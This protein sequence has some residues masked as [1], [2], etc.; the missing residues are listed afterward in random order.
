[1]A[2]VEFGE[3]KFSPVLMMVQQIIFNDN[4]LTKLKATDV[5]INALDDETKKI[6][7]ALEFQKYIHRLFGERDFIRRLTYLATIKSNIELSV[8]YHGQDFIS[9]PE[10]HY[11]ADFES[12]TLVVEKRLAEF[13]GKIIKNSSKGTSLQL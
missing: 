11:D 4:L 7:G 9:A 10:H 8:E 5:V 6:I 3:A 13:L 2:D 1:M 12:R